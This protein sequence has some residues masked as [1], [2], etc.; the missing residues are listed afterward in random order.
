MSITV[1][2][3]NEAPTILAQS[4]SVPENSSNGLTVGTVLASDV[5]ANDIRTFAI[6]S[7]NNQGAFAI[8]SAGVIT[9]AD[10]TKLDFETTPTFNLTASVTD[11]GT[12]SNSNAVTINFTNVSEAPTLTGGSGTVTFIKKSKT[13]VRLLPNIAVDD[14]DGTKDLAKVVISFFV[15]KGGGCCRM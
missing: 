3:V 1:H 6:T 8:S 5:D 7:G 14:P 15:P 9:V 11:S 13:P 10:S 12:L 2:N 4:F